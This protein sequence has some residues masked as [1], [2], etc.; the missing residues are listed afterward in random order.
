M[1]I[2]GIILAGIALGLLLIPAFAGNDIYFLNTGSDSGNF[3]DSTTASNRG[4]QIC[5][6]PQVGD[7]CIGAFAGEVGDDLQFYRLASI[8][9]CIELF[10][11]NATY[12]AV[13]FN[14]T[15]GGDT[16][17]CGN[18]GVGGVEIHD[19]TSNCNA[20]SLFQG[21]NMAISTN[22]TII[23]IESLGTTQNVGV[24]TT[25]SRTSDL[26][27]VNAGT[28][29]KTITFYDIENDGNIQ[30]DANIVMVKKVDSSTNAVNLV[31]SG[32][33]TIDGK[34][35][36]SLVN[37]NDAIIVSS[38]G[39]ITDT[40]RILGLYNGTNLIS[41]NTVCANVGTGSNIY[42]DGEC[43]FRSVLGSSD[44]SVTQQTNTIT[45]D[46]N[47]TDN[48]SCTNTGTGEAICESANNINS[49]IATSP[50]GIS[51]TT[52]DLTLTCSTCITTG[53]NE[54]GRASPSDG[55][56][57]ISISPITA[58][59]YLHVIASIKGNTAG[60]TL[61]EI[62][63]RFN[64]DAG[65]N[66]VWREYDNNGAGVDGDASTGIP[67][68]PNFDD[69]EF[70]YIEADI[71]NVSAQTKLVIIESTS[72][73]DSST[74]TTNPFIYN[75]V[76]KWTNTSSQITRIDIGMTSGT[77]SFDSTSQMVVYGHN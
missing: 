74:N 65:T 39:A 58:N 14:C 17:V 30:T 70:V 59:K 49:L 62:V 57:S 41:D 53:Y 22:G 64:N 56:T 47:G 11:I 67:V 69:T 24:D 52:G 71:I 13:D 43:N 10:N 50:L 18:L 4:L 36:V 19:E 26:I 48:N 21:S 32:D 40:W 8:D 37:Q 3:T 38:D 73:M 46:F 2:S 51:D 44:I 60:S 23:V 34:T 76:G 77:A 6:T 42:K 9:D 1:K 66:Y 45:V 16:T 12:N 29:V 7:E 35:T 68:R 28:G 33:D 27:D 63:F 54:L 55:D 25:V 15:T 5:D 61:G 75:A 20:R 31:R 72:N